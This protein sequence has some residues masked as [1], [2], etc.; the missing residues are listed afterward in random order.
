M[1]TPLVGRLRDILDNV[2]G[3]RTGSTFFVHSGTGSSS[4]TGKTASR[5]K[6]TISQALALCTANKGDVVIVMPGHAETVSA[7]AGIAVDVAGVSIIGRGTGSLRPTVTFDTVVGADLDVDAAN[8]TIENFL[9]LGGIDALTGPID[10]NAA[11][12]RLLDIETRDVTGQTVDFIVTDANADRLLIDGWVHR[13]AAA[14]GAATAL[15]IVGGDGITVRNFWI[16]GNFSV[17][18]I[19]NV[20]TA[21]TNLTVGGGGANYIRTRNAAD[22][23]ITLVATTTGNVGPGIY[24]RLADDAD[25]ITEALVGADAQFFPPLYIVNAD[26]QKGVEWDGTASA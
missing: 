18:A 1:G 7:A 14:A 6:A 10:I 12:C 21:A 2:E 4:N 19:E 26:G 24:M 3:G 22:V 11:D 25:N 20:T 23:A 17:A 8:V 9:F 5:P 13:G 16:D 15:S